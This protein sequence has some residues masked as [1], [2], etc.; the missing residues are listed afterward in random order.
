MRLMQKR[1][2]ACAYK[3]C[4]NRA[5]KRLVLGTSKLVQNLRLSACL[6]ATIGGTICEI[7]C[8]FS[9]A[10]IRVD[11]IHTPGLCRRLVQACRNRGARPLGIILV[12][13]SAPEPDLDKHCFNQGIKDACKH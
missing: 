11:A 13:Q 9:S 7:L 10:L 4:A 1:L 12:E 3:Q 6:F 8:Y 5:L 2:S